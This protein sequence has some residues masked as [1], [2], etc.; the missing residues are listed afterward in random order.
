MSLITTLEHAYAS[1]ASEVVTLAKYVR[2]TVLQ[3]LIKA[4]G[5][6]QTV[7]AITALVS[8]AAANIERTGFALLGIAIKAIEDAGSAADAGGVNISLDAALIADLKSIL[9]AVEA[10]AAGSAP[11]KAP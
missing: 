5:S 8:P 7:E 3:A 4:E 11:V 1:A 2:G 10:Q 6:A 9:P